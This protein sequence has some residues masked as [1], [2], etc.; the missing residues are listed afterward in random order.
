MAGSGWGGE[1]S[2]LPGTGSGVRRPYLQGKPAGDGK[3][4]Q[5]QEEAQQADQAVAEAGGPALGH[6]WGPEERQLGNASRCLVQSPFRGSS[7][8]RAT[9][10]LFLA[11]SVPVLRQVTAGMLSSP[12]SN[13]PLSSLILY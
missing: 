11:C 2:W 6:L 1:P 8:L 13:D 5:Q 9:W 12:G 4:K 10:K 7:L 3:G